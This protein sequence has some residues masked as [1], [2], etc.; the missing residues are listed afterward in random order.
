V[1]TAGT[2]QTG[3]DGIAATDLPPGLTEVRHLARHQIMGLTGAFLLGMAANLTGLPSETSGGA[4]VASMAFL[5]VHVLAE[6]I[7][8]AFPETKV[9]KT[10]SSVPAALMTNPEH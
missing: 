9:D 6:K 2:G 8:A 4:H 5:V 10:L 1:T 3:H 7:Q